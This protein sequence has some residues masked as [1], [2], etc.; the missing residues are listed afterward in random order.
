MARKTL[1]EKTQELNQEVVQEAPE[2]VSIN[3]GD[4][5]NVGVVEEKKETRGRKKGV[6]SQK[7]PKITTRVSKKEASKQEQ[8]AQIDFLI[9]SAFALV[10]LKGGVHWVVTPE[11]SK[12]LSVPLANILEKY[13]LMEKA[14]A[15]SDPVALMV[16]S[17]T[18]VLPRVI[19]T[20]MTKPAKE[21]QTL[22]RNGAIESK[23]IES[24]RQPIGEDQATP[25]STDGDYIKSV[26]PAIQN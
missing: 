10:A 21:K 20:Q 14:S 15:V 7:K 1:V 6:T 5:E 25:T 11:E 3:L 9:Q 19:A 16:A 23:S 22:E 18:I 17:V 12:T 2:I 26:Y 8:V 13:D 24:S 4:E